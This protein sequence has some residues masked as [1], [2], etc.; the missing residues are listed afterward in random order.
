MIDPGPDDAGH[1]DRVRA[2]VRG[3]RRD[4]RRRAHPLPRD[5]SG[6]VECSARRLAFGP[7]REAAEFGVSRGARRDPSS[8]PP[9]Q[10]GAVQ[11]HR[12]PGHAARPRRLRPRRRLLLRRPDP[13]RGLGDRPAGGVRRL[14]RRL[15][16]LARRGR[17]AR[18]RRCSPR[19][20]PL[21]HGPEGKIDE[22]VA[23][24]LERERLLLAALEPGE[25]SRDDAARRRLGRRPRAAAPGRR[26]RDAGAPREAR[27]G[28]RVDLGASW[29]D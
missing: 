17:G 12:H 1:I 10:V 5:H 3:A 27:R 15:H 6:G 24:R 9:A 11:L 2:D 20:R 28:G 18:L 25:R 19:P 26:A 21:D 14:A 8:R 16:A 13:R 7:S 22:Y 23:H 29:R 4:R